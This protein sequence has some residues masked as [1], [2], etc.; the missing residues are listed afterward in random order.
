MGSAYLHWFNRRDVTRWLG[1]MQN[2]YYKQKVNPLEG[3]W[4]EAFG[5]EEFWMIRIQTMGL[6]CQGTN[7]SV[8]IEELRSRIVDVESSCPAP[9]VT[10]NNLVWSVEILESDCRLAFQGGSPTYQ[11]ETLQD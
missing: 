6:L 2:Q 3:N 10:K 11:S 8:C 1:Q 9:T 4:D 5:N 7:A